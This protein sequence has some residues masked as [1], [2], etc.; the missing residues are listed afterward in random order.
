MFKFLNKNL[1]FQTILLIALLSYS[2]WLIFAKLHVVVPP[3]ISTL[4]SALLSLMTVKPLLMKII[5]LLTLLFQLILFQHLF[6]RNNLTEGTLLWPSIFYLSMLIGSNAFLQVTPVFFINLIVL[7]LLLLNS[8]Y[9]ASSIKN[10]VFFS[11]ILIGIGF[12]MDFGTALLLVFIT[13][14]LIINRFSKTKDIFLSLFGFLIPLI[15]FCSYFFFTDQLDI[16]GSSISKF[17]FFGFI[18]SIG[19]LTIQNMIFLGFTTVG[20]LY[21]IIT[22][23]VTFSQKLI[24]LR[25]RLA[26][27]NVLTA[28]LFVLSFVSFEY[29]PQ[30]FAWLF[31]PMS[32]YFSLITQIK[33]NW[34]IHDLI[35]LISIILLCL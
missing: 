22:L 35:I 28:S 30:I 9:D 3:G 24:V 26:V 20:L 33:K 7:L 8:E 29:Y 21:F 12:F 17:S 16:L 4:S 2:G 23:S 10:R 19:L 32:I 14:S 1:I 34:V 6:R 13:I 31:I 27:I 25:R 15:Y 11:G 5:V 18:N